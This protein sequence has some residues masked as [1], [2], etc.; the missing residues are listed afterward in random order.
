MRRFLAIAILIVASLPAAQH[1]ARADD[2]WR[3]WETFRKE[4]GSCHEVGAGARSNTRGPHLNA[5]MGRASASLKYPYS[6]VMKSADIV[7][8]TTNMLQFL[9]DPKTIMPGSKH[10][11]VK[12]M[13]SDTDAMDIIA[14]LA[15]FDANGALKQ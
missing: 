12:P 9:M 14:Y 13:A 6:S 11:S 15:R 3:G 8:Q 7:W 4:C 2:A 10:G 5:I 1:A